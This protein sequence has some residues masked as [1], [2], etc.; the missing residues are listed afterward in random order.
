MMA[1][2]AP[3][4]TRISA[5]K[6]CCWAGDRRRTPLHL[7]VGCNVAEKS[8]NKTLPDLSGDDATGSLELALGVAAQFGMIASEA[9]TVARDV[10]KTV[11]RWRTIAAKHGLTPAQLDRM[12][13]AFEHA[14]L[15]AAR[16]L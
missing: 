13:S 12:A 10:G 16:A 15:R 11:A 8:S 1:T 4:Q 6:D 2:I 3:Q 5:S 14:D 7:S 9:R